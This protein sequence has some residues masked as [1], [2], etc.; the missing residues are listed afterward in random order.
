[1]LIVGT[2]RMRVVGLGGAPDGTQHAV[3]RDG[4]VLCRA[5][6]ARFAWPAL[7]WDEHHGEDVTCTLCAQVRI[8]QEALSQVPAYPVAPA[9]TALMLWQPSAGLLHSYES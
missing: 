4:R 9:T 2:D 1:M 8:A 7:P 6:R 5:S 3:D